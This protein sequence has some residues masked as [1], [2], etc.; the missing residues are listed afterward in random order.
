MTLATALAATV[1]LERTERTSDESVTASPSM[2]ATGFSSTS[3]LLAASKPS[4]AVSSPW[5]IGKISNLTRSAPL[6]KTGANA[7]SLERWPPI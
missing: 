2:A 4:K 3:T 1:P 7:M 5:P 6:S